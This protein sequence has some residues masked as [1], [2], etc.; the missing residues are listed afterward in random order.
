MGLK[1]ERSGS[2]LRVS[3]DRDASILRNATAGRLLVVDGNI[4]RTLDLDLN[5]LRSGSILYTPMSDNAVLRLNVLG[6]ESATESVRVVGGVP[7]SLAAPS[8]I[9]AT[10]LS[11]SRTTAS[12][13]TTT[14]QVIGAS[15]SVTVAASSVGELKLESQAAVPTETGALR[16][17]ID[18]W[19][20]PQPKGSSRQTVSAALPNSAAPEIATGMM[21][22]VV[23]LPLETPIAPPTAAAGDKFE[24]A[25]LVS[26]KEPV[27]PSRRGADPIVG[28]STV[29]ATFQ[30][31][32]KGSVGK[33]VVTKGA[34]VFAEQVLDALRTRVYE[35]AKLNGKPID[36]QLNVAY[37]FKTQ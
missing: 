20:M 23:E 32:A 9:S 30:V 25:R 34:V 18:S 8:P 37:V 16:P 7:S 24:P 12:A 21:L 1:V 26:G 31:S 13:A 4:Q 36:S 2:D 22:P 6:A 17:R 14:S 33:V 15:D 29:E 5:E 3:W 11:S 28:P 35:P 19:S 10:R 27:Y